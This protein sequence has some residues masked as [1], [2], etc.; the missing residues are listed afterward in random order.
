MVTHGSMSEFRPGGKESWS[1]YTERLEH[2]FAANGVTEV[3]KKRS[4]FLA[5]CG[6]AMFR[7]LK[8]LTDT[9]S[10]ST[11][12]YDGICKLGKGYFEPDPSPIVQWFKF[13][14]RFRKPGETIAAYIAALRELGQHCQYA[15][16]SEMLQDRLV[17]G[18]NHEGIQKSL[19]AEKEL[20]FEKALNKAQAIEAAEADSKNFK[21][22][23]QTTASNTPQVL[24]NHSK[25]A[26]E[27]TPPQGKIVCY[28]CGGN[29]LAP[30]CH[31]KDIECNFCKK[32]G[33]LARVCRAK[34]KTH[35]N[36]KGS[37]TPKRNLFVAEQ[38]TDNSTY[39]MYTIFYQ[40]TSEP[41]KVKVF[42]NEVP[43]NMILDT[44]AS[45]SIISEATF[46]RIKEQCPTV[47][48]TPPTIR[49]QTYTGE[50]LPLIGA[51]QLSVRY[52]NT[53]LIY[54]YKW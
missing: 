54:L 48:L 5:V 30:A 20:T 34:K 53:E 41:M 24:F 7:L 45:M 42:L 49:L 33:H 15:N 38:S 8:T 50:L 6:A 44:G 10:F 25:G 36:P 52:E 4:I 12:D 18:V 13:N 9:D 35:V 32:K 2:Y 11:M 43:V 37:H 29:H 1:T 22:V 47:S 40:S 46:N 14:T 31:Y 26:R 17:C 23:N 39:K 21:A 28:R 19:L 51:T 27:R 3:D 16:L